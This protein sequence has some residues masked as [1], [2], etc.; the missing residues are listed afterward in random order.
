MLAPSRQL[1]RIVMIR[2]VW[3]K[4]YKW[5]TNNHTVLTILN[6]SNLNLRK[7]TNAMFAWILV[8]LTIAT[9]DTDFRHEPSFQS[10]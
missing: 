7:A 6:F 10:D 2:L 1:L 5:L 3:S 4:I 8:I 9:V